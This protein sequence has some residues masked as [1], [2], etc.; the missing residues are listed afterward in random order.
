MSENLCEAPPHLFN[1]QGLLG[2]ESY[3]VSMF[4]C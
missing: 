3:Y 1:K 4:L 2:Y